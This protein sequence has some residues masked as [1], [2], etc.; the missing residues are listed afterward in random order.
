MTTLKIILLILAVFCALLLIGGI[1]FC[2]ISLSRRFRKGIIWKTRH[3]IYESQDVEWFEAGKKVTSI[4]S[5]RGLK[6]TGYLF[7]QEDS[8]YWIIV[9]HGY[10]SQARNMANYIKGFYERGYNV[11]APDLMGMGESEGEFVAMG[12]YDADDLM[13]WIE[14]LNRQHK[15]IKIGLM[16]ASMGGAT[17]MN[18]VGKKL[19][20]NVEFFIEDSGYTNMLDEIRFQLKHI[21]HFNF[22]PLMY[23]ASLVC[24]VRYGFFFGDVDARAGL[25]KCSLPGLVLHGDA[26]DFVPPEFADEAF[27]LMNEPKEI[28]YF[29]DSRHIRAEHWFRDDY[30]QTVTD[31]LKKYSSLYKEQE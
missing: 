25:K 29:K 30:W 2:Q 3:R 23:F 26:D 18:T 20:D 9:V 31:F 28:R 6:Q 21:Y 19:P 5:S 16:G 1:A 17:V 10:S 15:G 11:L 24:K 22:P 14:E 27:G 12:G 8:P 7:E 13:L 4:E